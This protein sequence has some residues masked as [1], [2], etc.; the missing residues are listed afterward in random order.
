[1][2][3]ELRVTPQHVDLSADR[4]IVILGAGLSGLSLADALADRGC[5]APVLLIDRRARWTNDRTWGTWLT[6]PL[7]FADL[8]SHRWLAWRTVRGGRETRQRTREHPYVRIEASTLYDRVLSRLGSLAQ[9][10]LRTE[11]SV[12]SLDTSGR[13]PVVHT[14]RGRIEAGLVVDAL[15]ASSP[16][17]SDAVRLAGLSVSQRFLGW[18][19]R[20]P[21]GT[22]DPD[23]VTL[24]DFRAA[25]PD[26]VDFLYVL[27]FSDERALVEH[28]S[29]GTA[30]GAPGAAARRHALTD[31]LDRVAGPGR[32]AQEREER[33]V[34]AMTSASFPLSHG[35]STCTVGGAA[36]AIRPSSGYAF[37]RIQRHVDAVADAITSGRPLPT[38]VAPA[39]F[40]ALD[41]AFLVAIA[42]APDGGEELFWR[43]SSGVGG[44]VF[45]R[46]M[47]D[48]STPADEARI[49]AALPPGQMVGAAVRALLS[50]GGRGP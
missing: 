47:T 31:E 34:I 32:W 38:A 50:A 21:A 27:P 7:R 17:R 3:I 46:F 1:M 26:G 45:A 19:V 2:N 33:G 37:T 35:P 15:G 49:L 11:E 44:D 39:R 22:F 29:I 14:D 8:A 36:G 30:A 13:L 24:M 42:G 23:T 12:T 18:E 25:G 5:P 6:G 9:F 43:L 40:A 28:T 20:A 48:V 16:L 10:E 4:P 41:R